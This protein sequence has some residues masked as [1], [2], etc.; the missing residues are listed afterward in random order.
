MLFP[1]EPIADVAKAL[2]ERGVEWWLAPD[3]KDSKDRDDRRAFLRYLHGT[4][5]QNPWDSLLFQFC[6]E[7]SVS[8]AIALNRSRLS[9]SSVWIQHSEISPPSRIGRYISRMRL[10]TQFV[11]GIIVLSKKTLEA[12]KNRGWK[13]DRVCL[14]RNGIEIPCSYRH[15]WIRPQLGLPDNAFLIVCVG[16]LI[17]RKGYDILLEAI[18]PEL[19]SRPE[20]HLLIIGDGPLKGEIQSLI[21][22]SGAG[23]QIHLL[24]LR[25]DVQDILAD[26]NLFALA[27]RA[28]G[29]TLAVMEAMAAGLPVVVTDVGGHSEL[30]SSE[31]GE[32][33][34]PNDPMAFNQAI[35]RLLSDYNRANL[36][37]AKGRTHISTGFTL[38]RQVELQ[39]NFIRES[40]LKATAS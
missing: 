27:S 7:L 6:N 25:N 4:L 10:L 26:S 20:G 15:G 37:G 34:R 11:D 9:Y 30:V 35:A 28:E 13:S 1:G 12:V 16:S 5:Q 18:A 17:Y 2:R 40:H 31:M 23:S 33:V 29:L 21:S 8:L 39:Y 19:K 3:W 32:V 14:I 24:G 22:R 36:L 38:E